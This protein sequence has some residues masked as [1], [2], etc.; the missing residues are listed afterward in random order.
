VIDGFESVFGINSPSK[1]MRDSVGKYLA[2]GI[3]VGFTEEIPGIGK[4]ALD[5]FADLELPEVTLTADIDTDF[6][7]P[8]PEVPKLEFDM[9][10]LEAPKLAFDMPELPELTVHAA[11][12]DVPDITLRVEKLPQIDTDAVRMLQTARE[13]PASGLIQP[14]PTS[15]V[16][17]NYY[18][19]TTNNR[20]DSTQPVI[21]VHV[22]CETEMDGEKVAEMV[23]EKV[24]ILQGEAVTMDERGTAH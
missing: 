21:N 4:A 16:T 14:S 24:D 18:T 10:E 17:N 7:I 23:A 8:E 2:Q 15:E 13:Y 5:A 20:T 22:H 6:D 19:N 1:V 3:G 12:I 11:E 9:P